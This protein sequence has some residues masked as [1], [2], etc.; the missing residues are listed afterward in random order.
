MTFKCLALLIDFS[1]DLYIYNIFT[2]TIL[3]VTLWARVVKNTG[4]VKTLHTFYILHFV[5]FH[6]SLFANRGS[7]A[8][9]GGDLE[10]DVVRPQGN[11][12]YR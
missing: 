10:V 8:C 2:Q 6:M 9:V 12:E 7:S 4:Y 1:E 3:A 11:R 5:L